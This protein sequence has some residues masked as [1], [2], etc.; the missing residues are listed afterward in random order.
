VQ[1]EE[2]SDVLAGSP[3]GTTITDLNARRHVDGC[4]RCQAELAQ[5]RKLLRALHNLRT[6]VLTPAPGVVADVFAHIE[7]AAERQAVRSLVR[8]R[9]VAYVGGLAVATAAAGAG[10]AFVL[11]T[12]RSKKPLRAAS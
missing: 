3:D 4:L 6:E 1:C 8:G 2:L 11:A 9:R 12:R 5:Y 7:A 10:A